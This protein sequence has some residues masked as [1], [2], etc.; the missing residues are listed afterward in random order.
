MVL[1]IAIGAPAGYALS[2]FDFAASKC[3]GVILLTQAFPLPLLPAACRAVHP[4][5]P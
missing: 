5:R 4:C 1:S 2:R 3:S